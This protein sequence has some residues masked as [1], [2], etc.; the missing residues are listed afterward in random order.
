MNNL[1]T[2]ISSSPIVAVT[3]DLHLYDHSY[4]ITYS[5]EWL[6]RT[7]IH[8]T[9]FIQ[10]EMF[11]HKDHIEH[12]R[13]LPELGHEVA[14]HSHVHDTTEMS[15]LVHGNNSSLK[16]LEYSKKIFEDFYG[17]S[18]SSFR[19][20]C[21]CRLGTA[22]LDELQRLGYTVDSSVTPQRLGF[23]GWY[24]YEPSWFFSS[25]RIRYIRPGLLEVPSSAFLVPASSKAFRILRD[26]SLRFV[27]ALLWE[28]VKFSDRVVTIELHPDDF[29]PNSQRPWEGDG[30]KPGDFLLRRVGGLGFRHYLQDSNYHSISSRV[31]SLLE[32]LA[33]HKT[34][35]LSEIGM[36]IS[37]SKNF[38]H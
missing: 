15:A 17:K 33:R 5:A 26:Q 9:Y 37:N 35:T 28:A 29:N 1:N 38:I 19:S 16:F 27:Q 18:P 10:S 32:I 4:D 13:C 11:Q 8:A 22:A 23:T 12:L 6:A 3:I 2:T 30:I 20:P 36:M 14:S 31:H 34:M 21:W 7:G 25:R 24:P